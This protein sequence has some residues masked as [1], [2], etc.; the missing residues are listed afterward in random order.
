MRTK[1]LLALL[2]F[3]A[4][5]R[6]GTL[7]C[8]AYPDW[9]LVVDEA[10]G[11]VVDKIKMVTGLPRSLRLSPDHKTIYVSTNDH[12]GF[13]VIDVATHK[14]TNHFVLDDATHKFRVNGG[15]PDPQGKVL[16]TSTTEITKMPDRYVIGRPKYTIID[17]AGQ[18]IVKTVDEPT[19]Q[20]GR[21]GFGGGRGGGGFEVSPDGKYLYQFGSQVTVLNSSDFSVVDHIELELPDGMPSG[22]LGLGGMQEALS[23]PGQ[24]V[25]LFNYSDPIV[26]NRVFGLARFDLNTRKFSF[27]PIGPSPPAMGGL[28]ITPDQKM[29]YTMTSSGQGGDKRCE[30]WGIDLTSTKLARTAEVPCRTRYDFGISSNGKKLYIYAAGYQIEVYDAVTFKLEDTWDMGQDMTGPM[31]VLP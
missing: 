13:E 3:S 16:Y 22:N 7:F 15:A 8:G 18:K 14:V 11:K 5:C 19:S 28:Y 10:S 4:F 6:A 30:F 9:V 17:L 27:T 21:G 25:S 12:N 31:V 1:A 24:R 20:G 23:Q 2:A 26:H 29:G